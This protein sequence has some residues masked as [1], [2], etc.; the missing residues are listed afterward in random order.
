MI[1]IIIT[2]SITIIIT[3][4]ILVPAVRSQLLCETQVSKGGRVQ[5]V[6]TGGV[7]VAAMAED[8]EGT[9]VPMLTPALVTTTKVSSVHNWLGKGKSL[10]VRFFI[11]QKTGRKLQPLCAGTSDFVMSGTT[12]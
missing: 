3:I 1:V 6:A 10:G 11:E 2:T 12:S 9:G 5:D 8:E 7:A 4:T